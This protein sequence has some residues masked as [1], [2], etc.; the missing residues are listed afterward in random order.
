ML[1]K[2]NKKYLLYIYIYRMSY[3]QKYLKYK[4]KYLELRGSFEGG[5]SQAVKDERETL[6]KEFEAKLSPEQQRIAFNY[7]HHLSK[8]GNID[9][10]GTLEKLYEFANKGVS[11]VKKAASSVGSFFKRT[12]DKISGWYKAKKLAHCV[13]L[14]Q[15]RG[16]AIFYDPTKIQPGDKIVIPSLKKQKQI[17]ADTIIADRKTISNNIAW[18]LRKIKEK[19]RGMFHKLDKIRLNRCIEVIKNSG[20]QHVVIPT[21]YVDTS[22]LKI[23]IPGLRV[24]NSE[25]FEGGTPVNDSTWTSASILSTSP[26]PVNNS[27]EIGSQNL[28][29][30]INNIQ[31]PPAINNIQTPPAVQP[32]P[33]A[34]DP[35]SNNNLPNLFY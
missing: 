19:S 2:I 35:S 26:A 34:N 13:S 17:T 6:K 10:K 14:L 28:P 16:I 12:S 31:T 30:A 20:V 3:E 1:Y 32:L 21:P 29:P 33:P 25:E 5:V 22:D 24:T 15:S 7:C 8:Y 27:D 23:R 4:Q 11:G 9:G 18:T